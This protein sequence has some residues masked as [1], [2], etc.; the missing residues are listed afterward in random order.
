M[1]LYE[2]MEAV[3]RY[4][5]IKEMPRYIPENLNHSFELRPYQIHAFENFVT[6]FEGDSKEKPTQ[7]L[8]H[9]AT[10][11]GKT[12]IMAG[13][14]L[15]L[16]KQGYRN[17]LFFVNLSNIVEKTKEN[18]N[19][20][21]SSKYL[22]AD[23]IVIDGERI[24]IREVDNFQDA[25]VDSINICFTTTQGLHMGMWFPREGSMTLDD[26]DDKKIVLISDEA[27]HLNVD[28]RRMSQEE[29][30]NY[31][32]W[33]QTV[34]SIFRRNTKNVLLEF[35]ATCDL[36]NPQIKA[37]Y[38]RRIICDYALNRFYQDK[39]S[40]DILTLRSDKTIMER[41]LQALMLSQYRL[42][43]FQD[44]RKSIRPVILF[45][46]RT[47]NESKEFME[48]FIDTVSSL[49]GK[50]LSDI[51]K[52]NSNEYMQNAYDYFSANGI[53]FAAL[54]QELKD[55][56]SIEHC[57][58]VNDDKDAAQKQILLNSLEDADNPYRAIFEVKKL[59]EGWDVLNLFDIV[60]LYETRQSGGKKISAT[61]ISEAQLIGRGARYC[62][63]QLD[64]EQPKF[65]RKYD[66]D[67]EN[68]MRICEELFYHCQNDHR[69]VN[70]LKTALKEIGLDQDKIVQRQYVLKDDFK[71]E[72]LY[73]TGWVFINERILKDRKD[74]Y[75]IPESIKNNPFTYTV[76]TGAT[77]TDAMMEE[78]RARDDVR[79]ELKT[80]R[81]TVKEIADINYAIVNKALMKYPIFKFSTLKQYFPN[82]KTTREFITSGDYLGDIT[83]EIRS[84][85][86]VPG[87][88]LLYD[89]TFNAMKKVADSISSIEE[90]YEGTKEFTSHRVHEVF[91]NK[92]RNYND[93]HDGGEGVS[94]NDATVRPEWRLDLEAEDWFAYTDNFGTSE[95]KAFVAFFK[96]QVEELQKE[97]KKIFLLRNE[98]AF[99]LYSFKDGERFEPDYVLFLQ[100]D[101]PDGYDQLQVFIEPKGTHLLE[102]DA[103]KEQFLLQMQEEAIPVVKY[104]ED[105][106]YTIWGVHFF[107]KDER[108][109]EFTDDFSTITKG[110]PKRYDG[111]NATYNFVGEDTQDYMKVAEATSEYGEKK[112]EQR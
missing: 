94:Q 48:D 70:E 91:R 72:E 19:N 57:V 8:F 43:V 52:N 96:E 17:F 55:D 54:A 107:N 100:K 102:K 53:T 29:E 11:S 39:Y 49:T 68:D 64:D 109:A 15:Y 7:V 32:S 12:L 63:F 86:E 44:H 3:R 80:S 88:A 76:M 2:D 58:S 79:V 33:E 25:D 50:M 85:E 60:R 69:Y 28:T 78:G 23:E 47:I 87:A 71:K 42:K 35:T 10:G 84:H 1:F 92:T 111:K 21:V 4:G 45:K 38:E 27:H 61:T 18:F 56:F 95:E 9:M 104:K 97:Y 110:I 36:E 105:N 6:Y 13:L 65:Q 41:A 90:R 73:K 82:L 83:I 62:P 75:G 66:D 20:P 93:P 81:L 112:D 22:F 74:V 40:K 14:M 16:Y 108:T 51:A 24:A 37:A 34:Q 46:A 98:R 26:F 77:G 67:I 31:R 30:L 103:W 59:D 101:K 106:D 99:H 5:G 89:A